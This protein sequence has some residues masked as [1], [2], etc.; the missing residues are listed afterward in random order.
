MPIFIARLNRVLPLIVI[1]IALAIVVYAFVST[2]RGGT[3]AKEIVLRMFW[4]I[5]AVGS[6]IFLLMLLYSFLDGNLFVAELV[7]SCLAIMLVGWGIELLCAWRF[8]RHHPDFREVVVKPKKT[9]GK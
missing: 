1:L 9:G 5:C 2:T 8:R 4:W 3:R 7:G 6:G